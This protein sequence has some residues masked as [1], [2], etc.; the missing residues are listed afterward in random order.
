MPADGTWAREHRVTSL[1]SK[2][3]LYPPQQIPN[4]TE[5]TPC[6][7]GF[8]DSA[9]SNAARSLL[10]NQRRAEPG[11]RPPEQ[12]LRHVFRSKSQKRKQ[13][14]EEHWV[15]SIYEVA[16]TFDSMVSQSLL[17]PPGHAQALLSHTPGVSLEELWRHYHDPNLEK[18]MKSRST[19][20]Q[21]HVVPKISWLDTITGRTNLEYIHLMCQTGLSQETLNRSFSVALSQQSLA[22]MEILLSHGAVA[23]DCLDVIHERVKSHDL[24]LV[25]LLLSAPKSMTVEAW[26]YCLEP[27]LEGSTAN[28]EQS[29]SLLLHCLSHRPDVVCTEMLLKALESQNLPATVTI[30]AYANGVDFFRDL[31]EQACELVSRIPKGELR[32]KFFVALGESRLMLDGVVLR[33]ELMRNVK[34]RHLPLI[35]LLVDAG[36]ILDIEPHNALHWAIS[37]VALDVMETFKNGICSFPVAPLL[38][39]VPSSTS[40]Q[41]LVRLIEILGP[42]GLA[43][44]PIN[45]HL[46]SAV[47]K[48][49]TQ[50]VKTL[51]RYGAS[52][53]FKEALAI[54]TALE[55]SNIHILDILLKEDCSPTILSTTLDIAMAVK[56]RYSR[57]LAM[58]KLLKKG[59]VKHQLGL[60]LQ[61]LVLEDGKADYKLL[62]LLLHYHA[63]LN[64]IGDEANNAV[65]V[66]IRRGMCFELEMLCDASPGNETLSKAVAIAFDTRHTRTYDETLRMI[67][68]LLRNTTAS[69]A[70]HDTLLAAVRHDQELRV[71]RLLVAHGA[72]AN[73]TNGASFIIALV[74]RNLQ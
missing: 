4:L 17:P 33:K 14:N 13:C 29:P 26:R 57:L 65:F 34:G 62:E 19:Y 67:S 50:L 61:E 55:M 31:R 74:T 27:V 73:Y 69:L 53:E 43:G 8:S 10:A 66:A 54:R 9:C 2:A 18:I 22:A 59:V 71:V 11:Y 36:V 7:F 52:V 45:L 47:R 49:H 21:G 16:K 3:D 58:K 68:A 32:H 5:P 25:K 51:L 40:E 38:Q 63:P 1:L 23:Y 30:L 35:R 60:I 12:Q 15:F 72:D 39:H 24:A 64:G 56:S 46:I 28:S 70:I 42:K 6:D 41:Q 20:L 48:K 44:D 37:H